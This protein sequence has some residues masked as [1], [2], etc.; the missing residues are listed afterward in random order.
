MSKLNGYAGKIARINLNQENFTT[1]DTAKYAD[2][3]IGGRGIA[4]RMYFEDVGPEVGAFDP[5]NALYFMTGP[6]GGTLGT[7]SGRVSLVGKSPQSYPVESVCDSNCGGDFGPTMKFA[8]FDGIAVTGKADKP[9]YIFIENG[10]VEIKDASELWGLGT[11]NTQRE[12]W[13]IHGTDAQML[14]IGPAG[15]K[16][17]R[18]AHIQH[19]AGGAFGQGGFGGVMG[20]KNLKAIVVKGTGSIPVAD[21]Q[22]LIDMRMY[23]KELISPVGFGES[24]KGVQGKLLINSA[25]YFQH[26][27]EE[28]GFWT[29]WHTYEKEGIA[30]MGINACFGCP[31]GCRTSMQWS[32]EVKA[33][34]GVVDGSTTC[35][36]AWG[37]YQQ[38]YKMADIDVPQ[39]IWNMKLNDLGINSVELTCLFWLLEKGAEEGIFTNENTG[40]PLE[41]MGKEVFDMETKTCKNMEF[42]HAHLEDVGYRQGLGDKVAEGLARFIDYV[43]SDEKFGPNRG[44]LRYWYNTLYPK[45]GKFADG[46]RTHFNA[47]NYGF[48][49]Y[50][51][52]LY[53]VVAQRD[54]ETK[55]VDNGFFNPYAYAANI[56]TAT[57]TFPGTDE[58]KQMVPVLMKRYIGTDK[59]AD[60][61]GFED[62]EICARWLWRMNLETDMLTLC[63]WLMQDLRAVR[64]WSVWTPDGFGDME[65]GNKFYNVITGNNLTQEEM[66]ER[67]EAVFTL[68]RAIACREGRTATDD[69]YND[70]WYEYGK[71]LGC[72]PEGNPGSGVVGQTCGYAFEP[73]KLK[74]ATDK[75]YT[76]L[77]WNE[78][79]VP[80]EGRLRELGMEDV[81]QDLKSRGVL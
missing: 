63:D 19:Q 52:M 66:W 18:V 55:H 56:K 41:K 36:E 24:A 76:L 15:E 47:I 42:I 6:L 2:K 68:E 39:F 59:P 7:G 64:F 31:F 10:N 4:T 72:T 46:Y 62:A 60:P 35:F 16:L 3:Y 20:S 8:G 54:P 27:W 25:G 13:K 21:P 43:E 70:D 45:A 58:W 9:S 14:V 67:C 26:W 48:M 57:N 11:L 51:I 38:W 65:I 32:D 71:S 80:T 12:L 61:P 29:G 73:D 50:A 53:Q 23:A 78:N 34:T 1:V 69:I 28:G 75:F 74:Q 81:A 33:N 17:S 40:W 37:Y 30:K 5:G 22:G 49:F 79:G 44:K 77:G